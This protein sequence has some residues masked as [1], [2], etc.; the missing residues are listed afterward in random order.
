MIIKSLNQTT[1]DV[2]WNKGWDSWA[3]FKRQAEGGLQLVGGKTMP[4]KLF[5]QFRA[6]I[7]KKGKGRQI[8]AARIELHAAEAVKQIQE[9][10]NLC[11]I[12]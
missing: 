12:S 1:F 6:I 9:V 4:A 11:K 10:S 3:R 2:F 5:Q 8:R 7:N